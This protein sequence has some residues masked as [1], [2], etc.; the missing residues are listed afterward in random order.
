MIGIIGAMEIEVASIIEKIE[1]VQEQTY[2]G[3]S[4]F[5][6]EL[7]G[8]Q[9]VAAQCGIG[10]VNAAVCAQ[11][12]IL[13]FAPQIIIN[14][15]VAGALS[16]AVKIHDIVIATHAVQH[17]LDLTPVG[18]EKGHIAELNERFIPCAPAV[19]TQLQSAA[20]K[21][22]TFHTGI[23]ATGDQFINCAAVKNQISQTF[24]ALACEMEGASIAHTCALS[25]TPFGIVR[26]ISDNADADVDFNFDEF[27]QQAAKKSVEMICE[28]LIIFSC[29]I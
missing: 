4:F 12:M 23:I 28:Y 29:S 26:T 6:G 24:S 27:V 10:K 15:G 25:N 20:K 9:I 19:I 18:V 5:S 22:G 11:T 14:T 17:D 1:N 7:C 16:P 13:K 3:I 2:S 21:F 8:V